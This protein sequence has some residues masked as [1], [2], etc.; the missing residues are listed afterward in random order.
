MSLGILWTV[1]EMPRS[2]D[3][4]TRYQAI[5]CLTAG[6]FFKLQIEID[7]LQVEDRY[8]VL[9]NFLALMKQD[10]TVEYT[11]RPY[12]RKVIGEAQD[13]ILTVPPKGK[14]NE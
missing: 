14:T 1:R 9:Y 11:V 10:G 4:Y 5:G 2:P 6:Q 13:R 7:R 12:N 8:Q 3:D